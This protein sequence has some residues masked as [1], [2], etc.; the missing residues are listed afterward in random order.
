MKVTTTKSTAIATPGHIAPCDAA[1]MSR[2]AAVPSFDAVILAEARRIEH[3]RRIARAWL[4]WQC[5]MTKPRTDALEIIVSELCT[6][7]VRHGGAPVFGLRGVVPAEGHV[8]L[9][10][11]DGTPCAAPSPQCPGL[12]EERGR[13]LFLVD[14][15]VDELSGTWGFCDNG[16]VAWCLVPVQ[17]EG[18]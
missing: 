14:A 4:S 6:N 8:R 18:Q 2:A 3:A 13:G 17:G 11:R 12:L 7:A 15:L 9:E 1:H 5:G 16:A 10:V